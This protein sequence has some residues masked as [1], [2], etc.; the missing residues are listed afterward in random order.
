MQSQVIEPEPELRLILIP[1]PD[2][3]LLSDEKFR[4][5][6]S[7]FAAALRAQQGITISARSRAFDSVPGTGGGG[8]PPNEFTLIITSIT[9]VASVAIVQLRKLLET[10]LKVREGRKY[11]LTNGKFSIEGSARDVQAQITHGEI[12]Q[13][14]RGPAGQKKPRM[15]ER[16]GSEL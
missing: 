10:Y 9:S 8:L 3:P 12:Q 11:K 5:E 1:A 2:D 4:N 15:T 6:L 14:L 13:M 7:D 16:E